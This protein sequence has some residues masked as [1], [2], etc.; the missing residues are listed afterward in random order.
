MS[1]VVS[2]LRRENPLDASPLLA[3]L[4]TWL[5][6]VVAAALV[7]AVAGSI[8]CFGGQVWWYPLA[9]AVLAAAI[10]AASLARGLC[11]G[12]C[13]VLRSLWTA[14]F[15]AALGLAA[16][17]ALPL[18]AQAVYGISAQSSGVLARLDA[19]STGAVRDLPT[20]PHDTRTRLSL[21]VDRS[22]TVRW[23][24]Q[25]TLLLVIFCAVGTFVSSRA[26]ARLIWN[27]V[28]AGFAVT[29][30]VASI[31][32]AGNSPGIYGL[33]PVG[34]AP[35]WAPSHADLFAGPVS[36]NLRAT[37]G[38]PNQ[39]WLVKRAV[40]PFAIGPL[41]AGAGAFLALASLAMPLLLGVIVHKVAPGGSLEPLRTRLRSQGGPAALG[42]L[43]AVWTSAA[44][45]VGYLGGW[46]LAGAIGLGV[47]LA[48]LGSV[49]KTGATLCVLL[50]MLV[51]LAGAIGGAGLGDAVG[52]PAGAPWSAQPDGWSSVRT[53][54]TGSI[55]LG[56]LFPLAGCGLGASESLLPY[57]KSV[58]LSAN[59]AQNSWLGWWAE[60]GGAGVLLMGLAVAWM[61][62]RLP[63]AWRMVGTADRPLAAGILGGIAGLA[64]FA[65]LNWSVEQ[66]AV[67]VAAVA[68]FGCANRW[69]C[70]GSDLFAVDQA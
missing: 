23:L 35:S 70:G 65:T 11:V 20:D 9:M 62:A 66:P 27:S 34:H 21:S 51:Y 26:R 7:G 18:P 43:L 40:T 45:L 16:V 1:A 8:L 55:S 44:L 17:Q 19:E 30:L 58:D 54:W 67:A 28:I 29:T 5:D 31:Q 12:R 41:V 24:Y 60:A 52:R 49:R 6:R 15:L 50:L 39:P 10:V 56:R 47:A 64:A 4:A 48:A 32:I 33:W 59:T 3:R 57:V 42:L 37:K 46:W 13:E 38:G 68:L 22:K 25:G 61:L 2:P 53:L 69:L 63:Q 14:C 36:Y